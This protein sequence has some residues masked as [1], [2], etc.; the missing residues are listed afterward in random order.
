M[1]QFDGTARSDVS[2]ETGERL[3]LYVELLLRWNSKINLVSKHDTNSVWDRHVADSLRLVTLMPKGLARAID[4]GSGAGF[5]GLIMS[6]ASGVPFELV[7]ADRRKA[8]FLREA[9]RLTGASV[10]IHPCRIEEAHLQPAQLVTARAL[11]PLDRLLTLA[12]P[13]L[14]PGGFCLFP[15]G[16]NVDAEITLARERWSMTIVIS[17]TPRRSPVLKIS[18]LRVIQPKQHKKVSVKAVQ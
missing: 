14:A 6:I 9:A 2:R 11:A 7:E 5:P 12:H 1:K 15:K 4:L 13:H 3:R 10:T 16:D 18:N 17:S 8:S